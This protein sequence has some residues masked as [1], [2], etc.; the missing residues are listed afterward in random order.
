MTCELLD[1]SPG[2]IS[3]LQKNLRQRKLVFQWVLYGPK[4]RNSPGIGFFSVALT[5]W[6]AL[7]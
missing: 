5:I 7:K 6:G 1:C 3:I 2:A 4:G